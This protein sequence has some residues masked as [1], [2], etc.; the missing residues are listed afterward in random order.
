MKLR[1]KLFRLLMYLTL[2]IL[3]V[4]VGMIIFSPYMK[5]AGNNYRSVDFTIEINA[6]SDSVFKYLGNS[7]NA[8][9]WSSYVDHITT[10]NADNHTDGTVGSLRRCFKDKNEEGIIWDEETVEVIQGKKRRLTIFNLKGFPIKAEGLQTEQLYVKISAKK[11]RL[12][13][14]VFFRDHVPTWSESLKM[15]FASYKIHSI[16]E[17][18]LKNVKQ[19]VEKEMMNSKW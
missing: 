10:L 8:K 13:F 11:S 6:P 5:N 16:F 7:G 17:E 2:I 4:T 18:N 19:L 9:E 15:H 3:L 1:K 14:S 12:T